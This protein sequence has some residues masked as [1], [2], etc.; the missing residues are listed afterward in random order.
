MLT[1]PSASL[2][3]SCYGRGWGGRVRRKR[4][5]EGGWCCACLV[6]VGGRLLFVCFFFGGGG[7]FGVR[8]SLMLVG[9]GCTMVISLPL[10]PPVFSPSNSVFFLYLVVEHVHQVAVERVHVLLW[11]C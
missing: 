11:W 5:E 3:W 4:R 9:G 2:K 10:P 8:A 7:V 1:R 6:V